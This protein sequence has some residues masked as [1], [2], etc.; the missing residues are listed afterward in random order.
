MRLLCRCYPMC[1]P[2]S[3]FLQLSI[4]SREFF[5]K[6]FT[7]FQVLLTQFSTYFSLEVYGIKRLFHKQSRS[8]IFFGAPSNSRRV[9]SEITAVLLLHG[10]HQRASKTRKQT[11]HQNNRQRQKYQCIPVDSWLYYITI[12]A[13]IQITFWV[14]K[15]SGGFECKSFAPC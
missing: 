8:L 3:G 11:L 1:L 14:Q 4:F 2:T 9:R 15:K 6:G 13:H 10:T 5:K 12:S 7:I